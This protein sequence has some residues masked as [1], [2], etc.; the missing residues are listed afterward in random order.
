M[1]MGL[2]V[3][4]IGKELKPKRNELHQELKQCR[5]EFDSTSHVDAEMLRRHNDMM[6]RIDVF[7]GQ[8]SMIEY[9][10]GITEDLQEKWGR[11]EKRRLYG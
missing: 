5:I 1:F 7:I 4:R 6:S 3:L 8:V 2:R 10:M 11:N 9:I